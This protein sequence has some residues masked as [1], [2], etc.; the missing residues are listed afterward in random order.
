MSKIWIA[1]G[2]LILLVLSISLFYTNQESPNPQPQAIKETPQATETSQPSSITSK[3]LAEH[4]TGGDCWII[5]EGKVYD[6]SEA[7]MHPAMAKT[8]YSHCGDIAGFGQGAKSQHSG[9]SQ[10]RVANYG[11]YIG[12][13][14]Q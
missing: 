10:T 14:E 5:Y 12:D 2:A 7:Q 6:Y 8:F 11:D 1:L 3:E 9:S 4:N 13:L